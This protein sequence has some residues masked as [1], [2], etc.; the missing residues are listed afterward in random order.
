MNMKKTILLS[1]LIIT[2]ITSCD[3]IKKNKYTLLIHRKE[4]S[5]ISNTWENK[6]DSSILEEE[7]DSLAYYYGK[8]R[9]ELGIVIDKDYNLDRESNYFEVLNEKREDIRY[10]L[11]DESVAEMN[12]RAIETAK[13]R[14]KEKN[15]N[16][17]KR[18]VI[19]ETPEI[20]ELKKKFI[21]KKDEFEES[22]ITWYIPKS[23]PRYRNANTFYCYFGTEN[24]IPSVLRIVHQYY[25]DDWLFINTYKF[26]IDGNAYSYTPNNMNTDNG[27]GGMIWEWS[28]EIVDTNIKNIINQL[29]KSKVAKIKLDGKQYYDTK[30]IT[31]SQI[32]SIRETIDLYKL[33]GGEY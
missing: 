1:F 17:V 4:K 13:N 23:V 10:K 9:F 14:K 24:G 16:E 29:I 25:S 8:L 20:K 12:K 22:N 21:I 33:M 18:K 7:N 19:V 26:S 6:I 15:N 28:D 2:F 27:D 32:Q 31:K 3:S 30:S 11:K 5:L